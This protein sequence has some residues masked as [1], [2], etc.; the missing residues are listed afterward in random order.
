MDDKN[1]PLPTLEEVLTCDSAT[2]AEE[3]F[4]KIDHGGGGGGDGILAMID[5]IHYVYH[6]I[7]TLL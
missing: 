2:T 4:R 1:L 3:V 5:S 6:C 7:C